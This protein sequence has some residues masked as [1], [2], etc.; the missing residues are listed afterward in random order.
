MTLTSVIYLSSAVEPLSQNALRDL[1]AVSRRNNA[2][3]GIGGI[4]LYWDGNFLQYIEGPREQIDLLMAK[5]QQDPRH[6]GLIVLQRE[7]IAARAF[8]EW[9]MA[10]EM[11]KGTDDGQSDYLS[12]GLLSAAPDTLSPVA[13]RLIEIFR[14]Q[15][16]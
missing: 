16:R 8:P 3:M 5:V 7:N 14:E 10:F 12:N 1:L 6:G 15:L 9:S 2:A 13:R 4:L 11:M